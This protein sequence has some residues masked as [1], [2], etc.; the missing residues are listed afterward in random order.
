ML[1]TGIPITAERALAVG[2]V[3][4]VVPADQLDASIRELTEAIVASSAATW[5]WANAPSTIN[6]L[7][8]SPRPTSAP[9]A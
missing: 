2:L 8:M 1:L 6:S 4:R 7:S 5:L 9:P 3:N